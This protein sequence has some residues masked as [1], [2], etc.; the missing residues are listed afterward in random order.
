[1]KIVAEESISLKWQ[2][3]EYSY[4]IPGNFERLKELGY[5]TREDLLRFFEFLPALVEVTDYDLDEIA[6]LLNA[7]EPPCRAAPLH[8]GDLK[9]IARA[10]MD[11]MH[12]YCNVAHSLS[13]LDEDQVAFSRSLL[14]QFR[15]DRP[16]L[17][18]NLDERDYFD[19]L[20]P[21]NDGRRVRLPAP[22]PRGRA[23]IHGHAHGGRRHEEFDPL[24]PA[25]S[26]P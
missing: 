1:V 23:G 21:I 16:W 15:R 14:R 25:D 11:D 2:V 12:E 4:S 6:P 9:E 20:R 26:R 19:Y 5:E 8:A 17:R 10:W 3:D 18:R 7:V 22:W 13:S 24:T